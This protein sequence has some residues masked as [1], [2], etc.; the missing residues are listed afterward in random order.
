MAAFIADAADKLRSNHP[1]ADLTHG[2]IVQPHIDGFSNPGISVYQF[3]PALFGNVDAQRSLSSLLDNPR[4]GKPTRIPY[5]A[6]HMGEF[7]HLADR[8]G[9]SG[10]YADIKDLEAYQ[11]GLLGEAE[12]ESRGNAGELFESQELNDL[13]AP[14]SS[15]SEVDDM[16]IGMVADHLLES[17][18]TYY[19]ADRNLLVAFFPD[20][21]PFQSSVA[22][23][24]LDQRKVADAISSCKYASEGI[25][26]A[27]DLGT[28]RFPFVGIV[29]D[30][31]SNLIS[32]AVLSDPGFTDIGDLS[33]EEFLQLAGRD[34][35][36]LTNLEDC[37][38][39]GVGTRFN[40][41]PKD[42]MAH[43]DLA[44]S[45]TK[46]VLDN[47]RYPLMRGAT[48][49][50]SQ[51]ID[52]LLDVRGDLPIDEHRVTTLFDGRE[53]L[54]Q[55]NGLDSYAVSEKL[56]KQ[57]DNALFEIDMMAPGKVL[58]G[59]QSESVVPVQPESERV[60][61][62]K[63]LWDELGDVCV[64][65][66]GNIDTEWHGYPAGTNREDIWHDF[67]DEF[68][69]DGVTVAKLM[70]LEP[71]NRD[72]EQFFAVE[73]AS[74]MWSMLCREGDCDGL[75]LQDVGGELNV[76][77]IKDGKAVS[78]WDVRAVNGPVPE[79]FTYSDAQKVF[80][81]GADKLCVPKFREQ[82]AEV[83]A[84]QRAAHSRL[85]ALRDK[86]DEKQNDFES[87]EGSR[88][89]TRSVEQ[90]ESRGDGR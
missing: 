78:S 60:T 65:D 27:Y 58:L 21:N 33:P 30:S 66:D 56:G 20:D 52:L 19:D 22:V 61:Q 11:I 46:V 28:E 72:S 82:V 79:G 63:E 75:A 81:M 14:Y 59:L 74:E 1:F 71:W 55:A 62:A 88:D 84:K 54:T 37:V 34:E 43:I 13:F 36:E 57:L 64:D 48:F 87:R 77:G 70:G 15:V 8:I 83:L 12:H 85:D 53:E 49:E 89:A 35:K 24:H 38:A 31:A 9:Q 29:P 80:N 10:Q 50:D 51:K 76:L 73:G 3:S 7:E 17:E 42:A 41:L 45:G 40:V 25:A 2:I 26:N 68:G 39:V 90:I 4:C 23:G 69:K 18:G 86:R 32:A 67:E 16:P 47:L 44:D 5:D 6:A